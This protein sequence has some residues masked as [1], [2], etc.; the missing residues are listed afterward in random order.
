MI[1]GL[2]DPDLILDRIER[3]SEPT[4]F[5]RAYLD[6]LTRSRRIQAVIHANVLE[7]LTAADG[8]RVRGLEVATTTG[9]RLKVQ[10]RRIVLCNGA[11]ETPRLLLASKATRDSGLGNERDLVGRFYQS[12]LE[13]EIAEVRFRAPDREV[14][15][16]YDRAPNGVYCRRY[17]WLSP[18]AQRREQLGGLIL[19]PHHPKIADP[20][21]GNPVLSAM[22]LV[23]DLLVPEYGRKMTS[24]EHAARQQIKGGLTAVY[25]AHLANVVRGAPGLARFGVDWV[26]RRNLAS[27]KLPSVVLRDRNGRYTLDVNAEQTPNP[28]SRVSLA[29]DRDA[30]GMP[31]LAIDWRT[32]AQDRDMLARGIALIA[33]RLNA[34][35]K[36]EVAFDAAGPSGAAERCTR[37]GGHHIGT[38]RMADDPGAGVVNRNGEVFEVK[39]LYV[40]GAATFP[41]SGFANPTLTIVAL[42]LRLGDHLATPSPTVR[43]HDRAQPV[44]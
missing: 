7:I 20:S 14:R 38:A 22:F 26:R 33:E 9:R 13:G 2:V 27:R 16:D 35:G 32:T 6:R 3:F 24:T 31:R 43:S 42:A 25:A 23:K 11:L 29:Q 39:G 36:A 28:D 21:H 34:S 15:L 12:H 41:T 30:L 37:I 5:G 4:H 1:D 44:V 8:G 17:I 10:A 40:S 18:E 19:R